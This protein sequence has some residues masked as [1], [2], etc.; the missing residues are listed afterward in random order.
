LETACPGEMKRA[1]AIIMAVAL[2]LL[3]RML[4]KGT[5]LLRPSNSRGPDHPKPRTKRELTMSA[6]MPAD[7]FTQTQFDSY[8][9]TAHHRTSTEPSRDSILGRFTAGEN[10]LKT[11]NPGLFFQMDRKQVDG[12]DG[13]FR[14]RWRASLRTQISARS[15]LPLWSDRASRAKRTCTGTRTSSFSCQS[16]IGP[17]WAGVNSPRYR[18]GSPTTTALSFLVAWNVT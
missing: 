15:A 4:A 3:P 14:L 5:P 17:S 13:F 9:Q 12:K 11:A 18:D 16:L 7:R 2:C 6:T 10:I 1:F 8:H